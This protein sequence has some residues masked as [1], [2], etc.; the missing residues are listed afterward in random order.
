MDKATLMKVSRHL[1]EVEMG[2]ERMMNAV[3]LD[4]ND[5]DMDEFIQEMAQVEG[6]VMEFDRYLHSFSLPKA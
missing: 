6:A 5:P 2:I 1:A 4:E 3:T